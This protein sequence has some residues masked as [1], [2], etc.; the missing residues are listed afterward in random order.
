MRWR[1]RYAVLGIPPL[2]AFASTLNA[3]SGDGAT[4]AGS[5][6]VWPSPQSGSGSVDAGARDGGGHRVRRATPQ[7]KTTSDALRVRRAKNGDT[8]RPRLCIR[9]REGTPTVRLLKLESEVSRDLVRRVLRQNFGRIRFCYE[10]GL[11]R[12]KWLRG[13]VGVRLTIFA[14]G[15]SGDVHSTGTGFPDANVVSCVLEVFE[16]FEL[17]EPTGERQIVRASWRLEPPN[18]PVFEPCSGRL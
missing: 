6:G 7:P 15:K 14:D 17:H 18:G 13:A 11:R 4:G 1:S 8:G 3:G 5:R 10:Q 16:H 9:H 2:L 12:N